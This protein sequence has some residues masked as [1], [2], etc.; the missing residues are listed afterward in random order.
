MSEL[1]QTELKRRVTYNRETGEMVVVRRIRGS[2]KKYFDIASPKTPGISAYGYRIISINRRPYPV[3][4]LIFLY[5][6]G[7]FPTEVDHINGNRLDN[8]WCNL[9]DVTRKENRLNSANRKDNTS[10]VSGLSKLKWK[11]GRTWDIYINHNGNRINL[12]YC[13]DFFEACCIRKSAENKYGFHYNHGRPT[14]GH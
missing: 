4:R 1:T 2:N 8:R 14:N 5:I 10:G 6:N 12:G 11:T 7:N 9:R 13:K 3:H